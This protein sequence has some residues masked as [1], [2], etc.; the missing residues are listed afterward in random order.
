MK[1]ETKPNVNWNAAPFSMDN[2]ISKEVRNVLCKRFEVAI[3]NVRDTN[4]FDDLRLEDGWIVKSKTDVVFILNSNK[5]EDL[6]KNTELRGEEF[7]SGPIGAKL[8][9]AQDA[10]FDC[11]KYSD[12]SKIEGLSLDS[13]TGKIAYKVI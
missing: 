11:E 2:K 13:S 10:A 12:L 5:N 9:K 8:R 4:V 7:N 6:P 1:L 3:H